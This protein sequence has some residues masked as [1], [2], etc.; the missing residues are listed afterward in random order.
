M[1][2]K[3]MQI[4]V[5]IY[6]HAQI[7]VQSPDKMFA[8]ILELTTLDV[9]RLYYT[10]VPVNNGLLVCHFRRGGQVPCVIYDVPNVICCT[11]YGFAK[12][13]SSCVSCVT[14]N[15]WNVSLHLSRTICGVHL[16]S[17]IMYQWQICFNYVL[18]SDSIPRVIHPTCHICH[19]LHDHPGCVVNSCALL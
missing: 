9:H 10:G 6:L 3:C 8:K 7:Y 16:M 17:W 11:L 1:C 4:Y 18:V 14:W 12:C 19:G 5:H 2:K 13:L 15:V